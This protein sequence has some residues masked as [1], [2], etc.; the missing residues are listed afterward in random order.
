[1]QAFRNILWKCILILKCASLP[2]IDNFIS[3]SIY[4]YCLLF[5]T[6]QFGFAEVG[7]KAFFIKSNTFL[8][9]TKFN[10]IF[11]S[12]FDIDSNKIIKFWKEMIY[13]IFYFIN[14]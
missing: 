6:S 4:F 12:I 10:K 3:L 14:L 13:R 8:E 11:L 2:L 1:M 7:V 5:H 9:K